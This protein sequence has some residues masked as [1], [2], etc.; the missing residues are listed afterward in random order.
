[1]VTT[2]THKIHKQNEKIDLLTS[3]IKNTR[4][5]PE[6]AVIKRS[7]DD[8]ATTNTSIYAPTNNELMIQEMNI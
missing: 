2:L 5:E 7:F 4:Q 3:E 6:S 1:M 8:M